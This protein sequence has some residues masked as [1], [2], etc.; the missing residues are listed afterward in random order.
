ME[1][2]LGDALGSVR[3]MTDSTGTLTLEKSYAPFGEVITSTGTGESVYG[4]TG[5][6]TDPSGLVYLRAR[7]YL[8]GSGRFISRD[9]WIGSYSIP[10]SYNKWLYVYNNSINY[11]DPSG[12]QSSSNST[13]SAND[14]YCL[15]PNYDD[16]VI[17]IKHFYDSMELAVDIQYNLVDSIGKLYTFPLPKT[18]NI[19]GISLTYEPYYVVSL[20]TSISKNDML[21]KNISLGIFM[22][23]QYGLEKFESPAALLAFIPGICGGGNCSGFSNPDLPSDYLGFVAYTYKGMY[24]YDILN[25]IVDQ[26]FGGGGVG[27]NDLPKG[28]I[29][30]ISDSIECSIFNNCSNKNPYNNCWEFKVLTNNNDFKYL[31]WPSGWDFESEPMGTYWSVGRIY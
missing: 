16:A 4:Y 29:G 1:F 15:L 25:N 9:A 24:G 14:V 3:Q 6:V 30:S 13:C 26:Y 11:L 27:Q 31:S 12:F 2:F 19:S 8:P 23:F 10:M 17:D 18:F 28:L 7:Y 22:N 5:E 21:F 20:P